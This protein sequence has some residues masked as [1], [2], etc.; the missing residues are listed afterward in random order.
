LVEYELMQ[1]RVYVMVH[2]HRYQWRD[3]PA[4][5]VKSL[6][7]SSVS[8]RHGRSL[9]THAHTNTRTVIRM[10]WGFI[11]RFLHHQKTDKII[12]MIGANDIDGA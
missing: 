11:P 5:L 2:H 12:I 10:A 4:Y 9:H 3:P 7:S 8:C 6:G 1:H